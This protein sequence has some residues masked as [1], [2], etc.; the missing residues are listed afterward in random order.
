L[1]S[2]TGQ[3]PGHVGEPRDEP[4]DG[5]RDADAHRIDLAHAGLVEKCLDDVVEAVEIERGVLADHTRARPVA[6]RLIETHQRLGAPD[7]GGQQHRPI[8]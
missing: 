6:V 2:C 7:V 1:S 5:P 8:I 4:R 3:S